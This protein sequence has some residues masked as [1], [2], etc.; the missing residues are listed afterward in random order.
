M[1]NVG[2]PENSPGDCFPD[3]TDAGVWEC[4]VDPAGGAH[5]GV[6]NGEE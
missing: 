5:C 4:V 1:G 3:H 6:E 2:G